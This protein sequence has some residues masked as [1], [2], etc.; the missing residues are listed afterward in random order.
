M[1][2]EVNGTK[3]IL[4]DKY[5][6]REFVAI[7]Q[8]FGTVTRETPW[9][10]RAEVL[11]NFIQEWDFPGDPQDVEAWGDLD[12]FSEMMV[13]EAHAARVIQAKV[14]F[15]KNVLDGSTTD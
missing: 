14:E 1:E 15:A 5:P 2:V 8:S 12:L 13:I 10:E 6:T 7:R 9:P 11:R 4:R 3:V